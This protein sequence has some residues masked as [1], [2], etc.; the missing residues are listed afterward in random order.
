MEFNGDIHFFSFQP[1]IFTL[2]EMCPNTEFCLVGIFPHSDSIRR[3]TNCFSVFS[4]KS[5]KYGPK[6][7]IVSL[8]YY[9][10][11]RLIRIHGIQWWC[12]FFFH[13]WLE[14]SFL[15]KFGPT[16]QICQFKLKMGTWTNSNRRNSVLMFTISKK[17]KSSI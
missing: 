13:F 4:S 7:K 8:S 1:E 16:N 12:S 17:S 6:I 9:L 5:G 15:G 10:V 14:I 11:P 3:D 2:C